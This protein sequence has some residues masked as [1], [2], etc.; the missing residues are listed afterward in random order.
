ML[1][2]EENVDF[3]L[4]YMVNKRSCLFF[5][6]SGA[7]HVEGCQNDD[8]SMDVYRMLKRGWGVTGFK[9]V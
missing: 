2:E 3:M 6:R 5:Q 7:K 9:V 1:S 4:L 8:H